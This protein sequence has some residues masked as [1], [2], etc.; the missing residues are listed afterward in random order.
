MKLPKARLWRKLTSCKIRILI[1]IGCLC[2]EV[3][4][5]YGKELVDDKEVKIRYL[6]DSTALESMEFRFI[7][8]DFNWKV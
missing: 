8:N 5:F 3:Y 1:V 6:R 7:R 4:R 2:N